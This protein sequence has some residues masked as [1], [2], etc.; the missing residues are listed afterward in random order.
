VKRVIFLLFLSVCVCASAP[1]VCQQP[2]GL[3]L[4]YWQQRSFV[5]FGDFLSL[6]LVERIVGSPIKV[7]QN[8]PKNTYRVLL[9]VGSI[10]SFAKDG[11]VVWG[12]GINGKLPNKSDYRFKHLDV[13]AVRGP[14]TREFLR[15]NFAIDVPEVYGDPALLF[16]RLFPEFVRAKEPKHPYIIIPHYSECRLFPK[17]DVDN[18]VYPTEPWTDV[19][20]KIL[21]SSF[22][23]ASSLHGLIL[24]EAFG[25]PARMLR[26][27]ETE[28]LFK[29]H[30]YYL[31]TNRPAFRYATSIEEALEMGGEAPFECDLYK[32]YN[33]FPFE[34]WPTVPRAL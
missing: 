22:V 12:T 8:Y 30:D 26:V 9:A 3:P 2:S 5:N 23:I 1:A 13:R 17:E 7:H 25:I 34:C 14:L 27:T 16:P 24:A 4:Y 19:I 15:D 6:V 10:L 21:D 18:V 32:L 29:Y 20:A 11:D 33:A 28:P 31:G